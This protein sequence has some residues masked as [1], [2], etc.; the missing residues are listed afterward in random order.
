MP[1]V[2]CVGNFRDARRKP[3]LEDLLA[4][5][6]RGDI[7]LR[8]VGNGIADRAHQPN[9]S[10]HYPVWD[11][12]IFLRY[13]T[14]T[15]GLYVGRTTLEGWLCGRAGYVYQPDG[16][17]ELRAPPADAAQRFSA[18]VVA[19]RVEEVYQSL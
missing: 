7:F 2:L 5:A 4:Q 11:I 10:V 16:S 6:G 14:C 19:R 8:V 17:K 15:A 18:Q 9:I 1:Q 3:M 13:C 12:E